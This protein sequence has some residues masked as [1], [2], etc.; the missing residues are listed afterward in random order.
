MSV[1]YHFRHV[2]RP[3]SN[4]LNDS[5]NSVCAGQLQWSPVK[6]MRKQSKEFLRLGLGR[7]DARLVFT[8]EDGEP[9][10]P[11]AVAKQIEEAV[12]GL[13]IPRITFHGLRHTHITHLLNDGIHIKIISAR[14]GHSRVSITLDVYRHLIGNMETSAADAVE[15]WF[16]GA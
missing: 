5:L 4:N 3:F 2:D 10:S 14:A 6:W 7:D 8:R 15:A 12:A 13:D 1:R 16:S 11:R 9:Y